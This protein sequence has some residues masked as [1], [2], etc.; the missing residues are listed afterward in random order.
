MAAA[1]GFRPARAAPCS[2]VQP[3]GSRQRLAVVHANLAE[4]R[5]AAHRQRGTVN[6]VILAVVTSALHALL[7]R[8]GE[9]IDTFA[10]AVP[11]AGRKSATATRLGNQ[12]APMLAVLPGTG[13]PMRRLRQ[14][15]AVVRAHK[16]EATGTPAIA[17][18]SL[19]FRTAA[20]LGLSPPPSAKQ[21]TSP[22]A[23]LS[24]S[25][26]GAL[27]ITAVADADRFPDLSTLTTALQ[28][29]LTALARL[30]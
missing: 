18:I 10:V 4:V 20:R 8:R 1:G 21:A 9:G 22:S 28:A 27:T 7:E 3:T 14:I 16:A 24:L 29:E 23:S 17:L 12:I 2:L 6:D 19:A 30:S 11:V 5:A 13:D 15:G 26:A 25:Y